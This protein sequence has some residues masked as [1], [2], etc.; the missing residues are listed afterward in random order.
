MKQIEIIDDFLYFFPSI[1]LLKYSQDKY[2]N[3]FF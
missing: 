1:P 2:G 3:N